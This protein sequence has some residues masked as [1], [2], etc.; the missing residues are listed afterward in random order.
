MISSKITNL[1]KMFIMQ[2]YQI[3]KVHNSCKSVTKKKEK[4]H[5]E[6]FNIDDINAL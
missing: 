1:A 2:P 6:N 3:A 5:G 4:K